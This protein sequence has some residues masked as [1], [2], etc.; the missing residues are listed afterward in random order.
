MDDRVLHCYWCKGRARVSYDSGVGVVSCKCPADD[1]EGFP[2][3][4]AMKREIPTRA[5]SRERLPKRMSGLNIT[6]PQLPLP[7]PPKVNKSI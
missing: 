4:L 7:N 2:F 1:N 3:D 6:P 5:R